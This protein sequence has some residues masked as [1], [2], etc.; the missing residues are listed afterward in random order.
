MIY[1]KSC[2]VFLFIVIILSFLLLFVSGQEV[3]DRLIFSEIY[4]DKSNPDRNWLE[5]HNPTN[6]TAKL[7]KLRLSFSRTINNL[8]PE[9]RKKGGIDIDP[10]TYVIICAD[11]DKFIKEWDD[12]SLRIEIRS[13][14]NSSSGGFIV[15]EYD[16]NNMVG[17]DG[18]RYG[19]PEITEK[20][21]DNFNSQVID[22]TLNNM[23]YTKTIDSP[24]D[25]QNKF[26]LM[27]PSPGYSLIQ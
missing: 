8:P 9:I 13:L 11:E 5:I 3:S 26:V 18:F 7:T 23:S 15:M 14:K 10:H 21:K 1:F 25:I 2:V 20:F 6:E 27:I 16:S 12:K 4:L 22:F 24:S 17:E 19:K